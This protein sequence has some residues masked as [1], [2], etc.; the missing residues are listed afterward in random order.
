MCLWFTEQPSE[1]TRVLFL[2]EPYQLQ[3][4]RFPVS[5]NLRTPGIGALSSVTSEAASL[6]NS[7]WP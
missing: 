3:L 6:K 7:L 2:E 1:T 4:L 5:K